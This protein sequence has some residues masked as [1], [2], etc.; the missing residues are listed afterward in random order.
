MNVVH[1]FTSMP[2]SYFHTGVSSHS[3]VIVLETRG[4]KKLFPALVSLS[5]LDL[6]D[7]DKAKLYTDTDFLG[8]D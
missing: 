8:S 2:S 7:E 5:E 1:Q 6:L 4:T 3:L